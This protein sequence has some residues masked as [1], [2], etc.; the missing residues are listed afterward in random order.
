VLVC[1]SAIGF[2]GNRGIEELTET[3]A[4]GT[5]FLPEVCRDW[6][7]ACEPARQA[8]I[9]VVNLR[10]GV[11]I[12][13]KGG[14]LTKMLFPFKMGAGGIIGS[15]KQY[16]SWVAIDDVVGS[17]HHAMMHEELQGPVNA[18]SPAPSTNY[19][20]TKDLGKVL[21]R[22][23]IAPLPGFVAQLALGQMATDLLLS[24]V[25]VLP[26]ELQ[27]TGYQFR[28]PTLEGALRHELGM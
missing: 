16:W 6:E 17:I 9:R 10:I 14:A 21:R 24:S 2:Y 20:F 12:S 22:P 13:A 25:R 4:V 8:G 3:S 5:G 18:V 19:E 23:T 7:A 28:F 26:K 11:V 27:R 1:A 15:G